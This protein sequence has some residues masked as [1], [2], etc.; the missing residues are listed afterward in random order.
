LGGRILPALEQFAVRYLS[1]EDVWTLS[2]DVAKGIVVAGAGSAI[3]LKPLMT[4]LIASDD[5][6]AQRVGLIIAAAVP[7]RDQ[8]ERIWVLHRIYRVRRVEMGK[9]DGALEDFRYKISLDALVNV[10]GA[11]PDWVERKIRATQNEDD[12]VELVYLMMKLKREIGAELWG[13]T[14]EYLFARLPAGRRC[15]SQA[16]DHFR[17]ESCIDWLL[18]VEANGYEPLAIETRFDALVRLAPAKAL[19]FLKMM[20]TDGPFRSTKGWRLQPLI[21]KIGEP[22]QQALRRFFNDGEWTGVRNLAI[23]F[24]GD[25]D[26]VDDETLTLIIDTFE[27]RLEANDHVED[28]QFTGEEYFLR[29][30]SKICSPRLLR[31]LESKRGSRFE[32]LLARRAIRQGGRTG[33][34]VKPDALEYSQLLLKIGGKGISEVIANDLSCESHWARSDA[35][36]RV[37]WFPTPKIRSQ[38]LRLAQNDHHEKIEEVHLMEALA[39]LE[40]DAA[41]AEML[42]KG[43]PAYLTAL[44]IRRS[45]SPIPKAVRDQACSD[46]LSADENTQHSG[47]AI[48]S[49][50]KGRKVTRCLQRVLES[51]G[52]DSRAAHEAI[53]ALDQIEHY[54]DQILPLVTRMIN[55]QDSQLVVFNYLLHHGGQGEAVIAD[56]LANHDRTEITIEDQVAR[57][58]VS[59]R[60]KT[61]SAAS[62]LWDIVKK[63]KSLFDSNTNLLALSEIGDRLADDLLFEN[64][65]AE[66]SFSSSPAV[67]IEA[68]AS[69]DPEYAF[70]AATRLLE[71]DAEAGGEEILLSVDAKRAICFI[72]RLLEQDIGALSRWRI[73]RHLRWLAPHR[74]LA[75]KLRDMAK[76][77]SPRKRELACEILGWL[78]PGILDSCLEACANDIER[79]VEQAAIEALKKRQ[80]QRDVEELLSEM[81]AA[82]GPAR[83][84]RLYAIL[85]LFDPRTLARRE[86]PLCIWPALD[87]FPYDF[88]MEAETI[89]K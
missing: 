69:Q 71:R 2:S 52:S 18:C 84:S 56:Y 50:C 67:A 87:G 13:K 64:A 25:E 27:A 45:K 80:A 31:L 65:I 24:Q 19:E 70:E 74:Q 9:F 89:L 43:T 23:L 37:Q 44:K 41:F 53:W 4:R 16:I 58:L 36:K 51:N 20:S 17:D 55:H 49:L 21:Q 72:L 73:Y 34:K 47:I 62:F 39:S 14:K 83:W 68:I 29:L 35:L 40:E 26:L 38:V 88:T 7:L 8:I 75:A 28:W 85:D 3:V 57:I 54:S 11:Y 48:L 76:D 63:R 30:L 82:D 61:G 79:N 46:A 59:R 81:A 66:R 78:P 32:E 86:D 10:A 33:L 6:S 5:L 60:E 22:A 12:L 15:L 77:D 42:R 1:T